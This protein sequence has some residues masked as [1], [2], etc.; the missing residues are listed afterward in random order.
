MKK[1]ELKTAKLTAQ[2]RIAL[3]KQITEAEKE[4]ESIR[5][6]SL[7][8][9]LDQLKRSITQYE[10]DIGSTLNSG[11]QGVEEAW[12]SFGQNMITEHKSA[13]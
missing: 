9:G 4:Q 1:Q 12:S 3:E 5:S 13:T 11:W 6:K 8:G 2:Q 10:A 7:Q